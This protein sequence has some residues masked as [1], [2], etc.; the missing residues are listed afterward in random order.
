MTR[1]E[2]FLMEGFLWKSESIFSESEGGNEEI[3][4]QLSFILCMPII[5]A[6]IN[7]AES[8]VDAPHEQ[9]CYLHPQTGHLRAA[10]QSHV[11]H[12]LCW[13]GL[14][15]LTWSLLL[16]PFCMLSAQ[17]QTHSVPA[18]LSFFVNCVMPSVS[19]LLCIT[20]RKR[21]LAM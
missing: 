17:F 6:G 16:H 9:L 1:G 7:C 10:A 19:L 4:L 5:Q 21:F 2:N 15:A 20:R 3:I 12:W 13:L 18:V 14:S 8:P 11:A